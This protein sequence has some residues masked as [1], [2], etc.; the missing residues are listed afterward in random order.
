MPMSPASRPG[1]DGRPLVKLSANENPLGTSPAAL[2][3]RAAAAAP[4]ALSRSRQRR[5]ARGAR[6]AARHRSGADRVRHRLGRTA[7]PRRA[8]LCRAGRRGALRALRLLALRHRRAALRRDAGGG[9]RRAITRTDVDA[10]LALRDRAHAGGVPRQPQQ[11]D[12]QLP[13]ARRARAAPRR[14]CRATCCWCSTRPMPNIV[15]A[16]G[17]RRRA[18]AGRGARQRAGHAH[19]L[20]DLRPGRRAGRLGDRRAAADRRAQPHP[21][22]VQRHHQ[23]RR[24]RRWRRW[25]TRRSSTH[26]ARAQPRASARA[27]SRRSRRSAIT[28]CARCRARPISCWCCSKAR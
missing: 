10:L 14:R 27:S 3:A 16:G 17:R 7:Q 28:A 6:R 20:Q 13:A 9:A 25:P 4:V 23:R 22:A 24:R 26:R 5:P 11:P 8:G 18:G 12:R 2:A 21:R 19:L 1:A 15:D